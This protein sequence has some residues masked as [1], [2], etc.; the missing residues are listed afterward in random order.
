MNP[1]E[2]TLAYYGVRSGECF[3]QLPAVAIVANFSAHL[4]IE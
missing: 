3:S 1:G 2:K 4:T